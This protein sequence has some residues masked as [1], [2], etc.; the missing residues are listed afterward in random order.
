MSQN[1]TSRDGVAAAVPTT[2]SHPG[3]SI[4]PSPP[5]WHGSSHE[6]YMRRAL[7][8]A[9]RG[10]GYTSPNP[11]VG[12]VVV[13]DGVVVGEGYHRRAGEAHAEVEALGQAGDAARGATLY[14]TLE[15]CNHFG[16]TPPCTAAIL[17][18]GIR[19]VFYAVQDPN[20]RVSGSGHRCLQAA[21]VEVFQGPC[22]PEARALN[23]FF[24]HYITT[25]RPYVVAKFATSLDGK[26]ATHTGESKWITG[27]AARGRGHALRQS[28]DAIAVGV[29]TV[30]ADNPSL[31]TRI[32]GLD[33]PSHP[34]RFVLDSRGRAPLDA[35]LFTGALP[36]K[37]TVAT[38]RAMPATHR[39]AL[40][41]QGIDLWE[42]PADAQGRVALH[43][44]LAA[45]GERQIMSLMIE[46]GSQLLGGFVAAGLVDEVWAF[47]APLIIGGSGAPGPIGGSGFDTLAH[48]LRLETE[49]AE[50]VEG[51]LLV[52]GRVRPSEPTPPPETM[53][54]PPADQTIARASLPTGE[55]ACLQAS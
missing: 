17:H 47:M 31:T 52:R 19:Q 37:T 24:F 21:G 39:A 55:N 44:L 25:R 2:H 45:M 7:A 3:N 42:L 15:P 34:Q 33:R 28:C 35:T 54:G 46:G 36:G 43:A 41:R 51:D 16:R 1:R 26:I 48:A 10:E 50:W 11:M 4:D 27:P 14:V 20:P 30:I 53:Y 9:A 49:S 40:A 29:N 32:P 12:A 23:R 6:Y 22:T 18:A 38:T 13:R 8:L 5:P